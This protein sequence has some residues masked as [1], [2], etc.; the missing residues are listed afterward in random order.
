[1]WR[2]GRVGS[3]PAFT[4][5]GLPLVRDASTRSSCSLL[6]CRSTMPRVSSAI[7]SGTGRN[8]GI[9]R[10]DAGSVVLVVAP[11]DRRVRE[12]A[13]VHELLELLA[14]LE[15]RKALGRDRDRGTRA[16]IAPR[17]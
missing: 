13:V 7:C 11:G 15:E 10:P 16:G 3:K 6:T 17:V 1:M 4:R 5:S 12:P 2:S 14:D 8:E 9:G